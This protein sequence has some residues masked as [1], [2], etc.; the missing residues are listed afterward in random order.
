M[1]AHAPLRLFLFVACLLGLCFEIIDR[2]LNLLGGFG[3]SVSILVGRV[4]S[5]LDLFG[6]E[7]V[8]VCRLLNFLDLL[9][10]VHYR[11]FLGKCF[12]NRDGCWRVALDVDPPASELCRKAYILASFTDRKREL[13]AGYLYR[14]A[15]FGLEDLDRLCACRRK[16][17]LNE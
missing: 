9:G 7:L 6:D 4:V 10:A 15:L 2:S 1:T 16:G 12:I 8:F 3:R 13:V 11:N 5:L 17:V 14:G